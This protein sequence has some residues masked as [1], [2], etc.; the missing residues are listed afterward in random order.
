VTDDALERELHRPATAA[1]VRE[2][3]TRPIGADERDDVLA[4]VAWFTTRYAEPES[5]LAYVRRAYQRWA[6]ARTT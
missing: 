2:A 6:R 1:E 5:R 3:L 4:L